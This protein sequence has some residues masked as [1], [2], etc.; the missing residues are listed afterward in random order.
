[1]ALCLQQTGKLE[2]VTDDVIIHQKVLAEAVFGGK[3]K[4]VER[5][6]RG[7]E[8]GQSRE[9]HASTSSKILGIRARS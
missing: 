2:N 3:T 8:V 6:T 9:G 5:L 1:M 4:A 7:L